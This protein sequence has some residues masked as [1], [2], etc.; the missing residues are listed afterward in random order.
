M[1][2][3]FDFYK[4][5]FKNNDKGY[6]SNANGR[7]LK[8]L[9]PYAH[10]SACSLFMDPVRLH[11]KHHTQVQSTSKL[12]PHL[13]STVMVIHTHTHRKTKRIIAMIV[14]LSLTKY[15]T[16]KNMLF[17]V[18]LPLGFKRLSWFLVPTKWSSI[19]RKEETTSRRAGLLWY[20]E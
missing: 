16:A 14:P 1:F 8:W 15:L 6:G 18:K 9:G 4:K 3:K 19:S 11:M 7:H 20:T 2:W 13:A 5:Y 17:L 12:E 10:R